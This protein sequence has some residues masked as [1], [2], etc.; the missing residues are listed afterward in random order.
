MWMRGFVVALCGVAFLTGCVTERATVSPSPTPTESATATDELATPSPTPTA[1]PL[2]TP[3]AT[4]P[5]RPTPRP[6]ST[7]AGAQL[8][9]YYFQVRQL[10]P[11]LPPVPQIDYD[12][13][14]PA[15]GGDAWYRGLNGAGQPIFAVRSD[16]VMTP[17]TA[18]HEVGHAY[19]DVLEHK[20]SPLEV[21][22][23]YWSYRGFPGTWDSAVQYSYQQTGMTQ[24]LYSPQESWAEAFKVGMLGGGGEKTWDYGRTINPVAVRA[25]FQSLAPAH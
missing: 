20:L 24:W 15:D 8:L 9:P 11:V 19:Q 18:F 21:R 7:H 25:F 4:P 16:Y 6:T 10:Y 23:K 5:P 12:D 22:T 1:A 3:I 2:P 17:N 14:D 13:P